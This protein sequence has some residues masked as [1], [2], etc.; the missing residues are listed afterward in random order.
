MDDKTKLEQALAETIKKY[1]E[2]VFDIPLPHGLRTRTDPEYPHTRLRR[3]LQ[4]IHDTVPKPL[5]ECRVLDLGCLDGLYSIEL[6][7]HG[8]RVLGI[9]ARTAN[10]QRAVFVKEAYGLPNLEFVKGDVRHLSKSKHGTFDIVICSGIL[11]H[12]PAPDIF[13]FLENVYDVANGQV[14]IETHVALESRDSFVYGCR[15]YHGRFNEEHKPT[16]DPAVIE[17][18]ILDSID[19]NRSDD[20]AVID[21]FSRQP[22]LFVYL[23]MLQSAASELW[24][25]GI[26]TSESMHAAGAEGGPVSRLHLSFRGETGRVLAGRKPEVLT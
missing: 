24:H 6:A 19:R 5:P 25:A 22:R 23:R 21:E 3:V 14:I 9:E 18:R 12:L 8:A 16:D 26:G 10:Y 13:H 15:T 2:W 7:L 11:Y 1:G 20:P 17:G 4:I